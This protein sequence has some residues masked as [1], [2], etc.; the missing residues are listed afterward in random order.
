[1]RVTADGS[2]TWSRK[3]NKN[4]HVY[5]AHEALRS[6]TLIFPRR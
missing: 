3:S 4:L 6:N 1:V 5:F 2:F